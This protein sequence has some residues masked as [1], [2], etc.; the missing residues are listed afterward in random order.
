MAA[1]PWNSTKQDI[2]LCCMKSQCSDKP[3]NLLHLV[4]IVKY[5][6]VRRVSHTSLLFFF[7]F[8]EML[9]SKF[10][11]WAQFCFMN[12]AQ[13][14]GVSLNPSCCCILANYIHKSIGGCSDLIHQ[15]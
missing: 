2:V 4:L 10:I 14:S 7:F 3:K 15:E 12:S 13:D 1:K 9:F 5:P 8:F 6:W 11:K